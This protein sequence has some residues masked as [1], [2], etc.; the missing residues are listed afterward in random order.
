M[1]YLGYHKNNLIVS[2]EKHFKSIF[3]V[4]TSKIMLT[5]NF[6]EKNSNIKQAFI[7]FFFFKKPQKTKKIININYLIK[8][9]IKMRVLT[10]L[11][12]SQC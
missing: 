12:F 3:F 4:L 8:G 7:S 1:E 6:V 5:N 11:G 9:L 2:S 10:F